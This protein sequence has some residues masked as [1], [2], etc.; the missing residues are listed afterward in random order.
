MTIGEKIQKRRKELNMT[1]VDL[2]NKL[3]TTKQ[4]IGKYE[5]GIV[6]NIPLNKVIELAKAL[7]CEPEYLT[8]WQ[9][10]N[11]ETRPTENSEP[12]TEEEKLIIELFRRV[13]AEDQRKVLAMIRAAL[14]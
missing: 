13:P 4:T 7:E 10:S 2:A 3:K 5:H 12:L 8:G 11:E 6:T 14:E 1:Q 9:V